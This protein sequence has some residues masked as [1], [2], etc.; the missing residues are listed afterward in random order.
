MFLYQYLQV[1]KE[2]HRH[3]GGQDMRSILEKKGMG[4]LLLLFLSLTS[5]VYYADDTLY[6]TNF[7]QS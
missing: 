7:I 1:N 3:P 4:G 5:Q 6:P 2:G